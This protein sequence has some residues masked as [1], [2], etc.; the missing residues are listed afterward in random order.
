MKGPRAKGPPSRR[1]A[2]TPKEAKGP[3]RAQKSQAPP[4]K[5]FGVKGL[6]G[7]GFRARGRPPAPK[8]LRAKR[9]VPSMKMV[10]RTPPFYTRSARKVQEAPKTRQEPPK[11]FKSF[12][13]P[14]QRRG[15][16]RFVRARN[17]K[18]DF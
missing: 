6:E 3:G 10:L 14:P 9:A 5:I 7:F 13:R 1:A 2:V 16:T 17:E 8:G 4:N 18:C 15:T 11:G 12:K